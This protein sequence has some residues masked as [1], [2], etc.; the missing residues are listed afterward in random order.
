VKIL[1]RAKKGNF[2][3]KKDAVASKEEILDRFG[4]YALKTHIWAYKRRQFRLFFFEHGEYAYRF[5]DSH[6]TSEMWRLD[7][8][9]LFERYSDIDDEFYLILFHSKRPPFIVY[10]TRLFELEDE[11]LM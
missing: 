3:I 2:E 5:G 7:E 8:K 6:L 4:G 10:N 11:N 9:I 1:I